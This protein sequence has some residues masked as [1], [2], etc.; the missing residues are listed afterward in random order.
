MNK[1]I[2]ELPMKAL[3]Y[4]NRFGYGIQQAEAE[5]K[6]NGNPP[7]ALD[8]GQVV[9]VTLRGMTIRRK[10]STEQVE[11]HEEA[12]VEAHEPMSDVENNI[13]MAC[14][15]NPKNSTELLRVLGYKTRTGNY[16]KAIRKLLSMD[17]LELRIPDK[18]RSRNQKYRL[19]KKG[20][21]YLKAWKK[22]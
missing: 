3:G 8:C 20:A 12:H 19:T 7:L 4:V 14:R 16:K 21:G 15:D 13:L 9:N 22:K 11:A 5:L 10:Q 2:G 18:P 6:L 17:Y 1:L